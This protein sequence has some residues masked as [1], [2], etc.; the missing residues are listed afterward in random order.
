MNFP[1]AKTE[2]EK[3]DC[4]KCGKQVIARLKSYKNDM[5]PSY[6]QWQSLEENKAHL[7]PQGNCPTQQDDTE[8][9]DRSSKNGDVSK[10]PPFDENTNNMIRG[11]TLILLQLNNTILQFVKSVMIDPSPA[12]V[13]QFTKILYDKHFQKNFKKTSEISNE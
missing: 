4:P 11:E 13:G 9:T 2:G 1:K 7:D 8:G 10:I 3:M 12:M 5:Y 6:I